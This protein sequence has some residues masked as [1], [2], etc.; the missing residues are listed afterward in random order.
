MS[1]SDYNKTELKAMCKEQGLEFDD[2]D[3]KKQLCELLSANEKKDVGVE[4]LKE[5]L[6]SHEVELGEVDEATDEISEVTVSEDGVELREVQGKIE[7]FYIV[8]DKKRYLGSF[9][10][11]EELEKYAARKGVLKYLV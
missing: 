1:Y 11:K 4:D 2:K 7:A 9:D 10:T 3:T 8:K 5:D 6:E